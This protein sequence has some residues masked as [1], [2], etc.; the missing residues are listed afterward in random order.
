MIY[1]NSKKVLVISSELE[2]H[3]SGERLNEDILGKE[4]LVCKIV[5]EESV[6]AAVPDLCEELDHYWGYFQYFPQLSYWM[7]PWEKESVLFLSLL[8]FRAF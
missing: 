5:E 6:A 2:V 3:N 7:K 4:V 1:R 8:F